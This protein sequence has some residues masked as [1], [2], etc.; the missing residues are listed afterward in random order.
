MG[1]EAPHPFIKR[2]FLTIDGIRQVHYLRAGKGTPVLI[3][4][5]SPGPAWY[6]QSLIEY[7]APHFTV[8]APDTPGNG[9]SDPLPIAS[10]SMDDYGDNIAK[11]L[12]ALGLGKVALYGF[13]TGASVGTAFAVRH[14]GRV[15]GAILDGYLVE[16]D[17][18]L[19]DRL[20]H[21]LLPFEPRGDGSHLVW[22][23]A[24]LRDQ[25]LFAP[26][27]EP[28]LA[29]RLERDLSSTA[30]LHAT[31]MSWL[32]SG[33]EYLKPYRAAFQQRGE[34]QI[35]RFVTPTVICA[36]ASDTLIVHLDRLPK[37]L[38]A[39][40]EVKRL[41]S[42]REANH[43]FVLGQLQRFAKGEPPPVPRPQPVAGRPFQD[44]VD[45]AGGQLH[46]R[47]TDSGS[48][49]PI[50]VQHDAATD[51]RVIDELTRGFVGRRPALAFD[52]PGHGE[53]DAVIGSQGITL[54]RYAAAIGQALDAL[55]LKDVD[56]VGQW[57]G[58]SIMLDLALQRPSAV[59][60]LAIV[61]PLCFAPAF[62]GELHDRYSFPIE[63]EWYGGHL[64]RCWYVARDMGLFWPWYRRTQQAIVRQEPFDTAAVHARTV[65]L[66]KAG[67]MFHRCAQASFSYATGEALRKVKEPLLLASPAQGSVLAEARRAHE[68]TP[69]SRWLEL[70]PA[71]TDWS[72]AL[73][74]FFDG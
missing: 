11:V 24:R 2:H 33:A 3:L 48:G 15:L 25:G 54:S 55:G 46:V 23:W 28:K 43:A 59:K 66:L 7:L 73:V 21:Y 36:A 64:L 12:D 19:A 53:S 14:P 10:P 61:N 63:P 31:A 32:R 45:V 52:L 69:G 68:A 35:M 44:Y 40:V 22:L 16:T 1:L 42:D 56:A 6:L 4:H 47:R 30:S 27:Y 72:D 18:S 71:M 67:T 26:W 34:R 41:G 8:I 9:L 37:N 17:Q 20:A 60:H 5:P 74:R 50:L 57:G 62:A 58:G 49:R 29:N 39:G 38:P 51:N 13:H 70:R 65:S